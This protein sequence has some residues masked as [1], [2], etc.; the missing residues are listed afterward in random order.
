M[1]G[2]VLPFIVAPATGAVADIERPV[3][4]IDGI[5]AKLVTPAQLPVSTS[6][7]K[8]TDEQAHNQAPGR[9]D[10]QR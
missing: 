8:T 5:A 1:A 4:C 7:S 9:D 2:V 3:I 6:S 10:S